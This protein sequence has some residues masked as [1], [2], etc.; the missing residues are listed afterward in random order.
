MHF[1]VFTK[2]LG[3]FILGVVLLLRYERNFVIGKTW[4]GF[5]AVLFSAFSVFLM[6]VFTLLGLVHAKKS[7][8][9]PGL[10]ISL[11][12]N[13]VFV[14]FILGR[15]IFAEKPSSMQY[16]GSFILVAAIATLLISRTY[17]DDDSTYVT[18]EF[19]SKHYWISVFAMLLGG[20]ILGYN[21]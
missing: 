3:T 11:Q 6:L 5:L 2:F 14:A 18:E 7:G 4:K 17:H 20:T 21:T 15:L 8:T 1:L 13:S 19:D 12:L 16:F 10:L 9:N